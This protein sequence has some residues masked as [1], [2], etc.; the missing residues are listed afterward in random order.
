MNILKYPTE[1]EVNQ[2]ISEDEPLLVL[3]SFDE[4][5]TIISQIDEAM[6]HHIL[7]A[8]AGDKLGYKQQDIDKFFRIVLDKD[9]ADWTFV[10]P[11]S[12]KNIPDKQKRLQEFYK[13]GFRIISKSLS[14]LGYLVDLNIPKR[15]KRH[16]DIMSDELTLE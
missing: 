11:S 2:A 1:E 15:Y 6:E 5:D 7:L 3:I 14:E 4:K 13:D 16:F 9:G 10:C 12:Y 8:K